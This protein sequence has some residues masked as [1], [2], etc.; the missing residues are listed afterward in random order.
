[1]AYNPE[2]YMDMTPKHSLIHSRVF[3]Y[4]YR[5]GASLYILP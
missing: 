1:M 2:Y 4:R 3:V 5:G